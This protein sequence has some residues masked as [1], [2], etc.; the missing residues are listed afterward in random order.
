MKL[1][2]NGREIDF[3]KLMVI[4]LILFYKLKPGGIAVEKNGEL[5]KRDKFE[6]EELREGDVLE[7]VRFVGGG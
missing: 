3:D 4:D 5:V 6:S 7:L 1:T 2:V